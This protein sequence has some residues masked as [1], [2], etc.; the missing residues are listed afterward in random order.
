M[1]RLL[2]IFKQPPQIHQPKPI[3]FKKL[4]LHTNKQLI[5]DRITQT[6]AEQLKVIVIS[7]QNTLRLPALRIYPRH[8]CPIFGINARIIQDISGI[9]LHDE[10]MR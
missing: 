1:K 10:I 3:A 9:V 2:L 4:A 8:D 6:G 7:K 5:A